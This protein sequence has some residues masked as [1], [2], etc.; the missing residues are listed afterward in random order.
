MSFEMQYYK[1]SIL[2]EDGSSSITSVHLSEG[3]STTRT[4]IR[5]HVGVFSIWKKRSTLE[6]ILIVTTIIM[7]ILFVLSLYS[8]SSREMKVIEEYCLTE[9]CVHTAANILS[10]IDPTVNP[11]DDFYEFSC[12]NW[13]RL[14][15]IPT[16]KAQWNTFSKLEYQ[17]ELILKDILEK[18]NVT[19]NA[20]KTAKTY[21][22]SCLDTNKTIERLEGKPLLS[23]LDLVGGWKVVNSS[24]SMKQWDFEKVFSR[25]RNIFTTD[26]FFSWII[27][28][29]DRNSTKRI[30]Q[31][32]QNGLT[33]PTRDYYLDTKANSKWFNACLEYMTKIGV[34]LGG[35]YNSTKQQMEDVLDFETKLALIMDP[36]DNR[37][38]EDAM[39][40]KLTIKEL[41][42]RAT[43]ISWQKFF[44]SSFG[45]I[46]RTITEDEQVVVL[47]PKYLH[48][49][50]RLL[51]DYIN[52]DSE[53]NKTIV[54]NYVIWHTV[55]GLIPYLSI[56]FRKALERY[57]TV[58]VGVNEVNERWRTCVSSTNENFGYALG[59]LYVQTTFEGNSKYYAQNMIRNV[60]AAFKSN[61]KYLKWMDEKTTKL[62]EEKADAINELIGFPDFILVPE[63]LEELYAN[64]TV[65][66][67]EFFANN[68]RIFLSNLLE[69]M[70]KLD[71]PSNKSGWALS[72]STINAYYSP[73]K[74]CI[75]F[76]AGILQPPF[77][78]KDQLLALN[79]GAMGVVV[80]H[81]LTHG[82]DDQGRKFDKNG[83][84][85][86]WWNNATIRRF[87]NTMECFISQYGSHTINGKNISGL[88]TLGENIAD[89]GGLKASYHAYLK[90]V[91]KQRVVKKLPGLNFTQNQLFF[92]SFAQVWCAESTP[93]VTVQLVER[94]VHSPS[95]YRVL[96]S[97]SNMKEFSDAFNCP[98]GSNMNPREKCELW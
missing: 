47:A 50:D 88:R 59:S 69:D 84:M 60:K 68:L 64:I 27:T 9:A 21:Y 22:A 5:Y 35:E 15:P 29:D 61:F 6:K 32:D 62:A 23:V 34:L 51:I 39:Y 44:T 36:D 45:K 40:H 66:I 38:D 53:E 2:E 42:K 65:I 71:M 56:K 43:F 87:K 17:T 26:A 12:G 79:Y 46:N 86:Q 75:V 82:F 74:N 67:D 20:L 91:Q 96:L 57:I 76:P 30:I 4:H 54:H 81:E 16:G 77:F 48:K 90:E 85:R 63:D 83:N 28:E 18:T 73:S 93:E 8:Y 94:D 41:Q 1:K 70:K 25:L 19:L 7:L 14:N 95:V 24:I 3:I 37:V 58:F 52:V 78:D 13:I 92:I 31:I 11:C 10:S 97:V 80:G 98:L 89:N 49:L 72:P 55:K 33:L